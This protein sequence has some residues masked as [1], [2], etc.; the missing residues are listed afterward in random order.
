MGTGGNRDHRGPLIRL[1]RMRRAQWAA[2]LA[3]LFVVTLWMV[4]PLPSDLAGTVVGPPGDNLFFVWLVD[5][6]RVT[7]SDGVLPLDV[8]VLNA[9]QGWHLAFNEMTPSMALLGLPGFLAGGPALAYNTTFLLSFVLTGWFGALWV[10]RLTGRWAPAI[11]AGG[12]LAFAPYRM[13]HAL[14]HLNLMGTQWVVLYLFCLTTWLQQGGRRWAVGTALSLVAVAGTSQYYLFMAGL[15]SLVFAWSLLRARPGWSRSAVF[16]NEAGL[17]V[18]VGLPPIALLVWPYIQ[19]SQAGMLQA[20]TLD[21]VRMWSASPTD[22]LLPSPLHWALGSWV[23]EHFDRSLW[24]E[25]TISVGV[26]TLVLAVIGA[27]SAWRG[28]HATLVR[29][30]TLSAAVTAVLALGTDLRWLGRVVEIPVPSVLQAWVGGPRTPVILPGYLLFDQLPF[31]ASMRVWMRWGYFVSIC[32]AP[33]AGFGV[34]RLMGNRG[35]ARAL[36]VASALVVLI[37]AE[38]AQQPYPVASIAPRPVDTWL[39]AQPG[40]GLVV[41]LPVAELGKPDHTF[42]TVF[43]RKPF[44]GAFFGAFLTP[45]FRRYE[46][47]LASFPSE[48]ATGALAELGA[49]WV[50]VD[51]TLH[52]DPASLQSEAEALGWR[53]ATT[54]GTQIVFER[55]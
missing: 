7:L 18:T 26:V 24:V 38:L 36:M 16:W 30:L 8:P 27:R 55:R 11:I 20:R 48:A 40:H 10:K 25:S 19:L 29:A 14:G 2:F 23:T 28:P 9:P 54:Q 52:R 53:V 6:Y 5:W 3:I 41:Q 47:R 39:A 45:Q 13:S 49:R 15:I 37:G 44:A 51:T 50:L 4:R 1:R 33:L 21:Q 22:F 34:V 32:L 35:Q 46:P 17:A 42:Y 12:V 31:Y 43:H